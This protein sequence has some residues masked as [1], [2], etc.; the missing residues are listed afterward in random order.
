MSICHGSPAKLRAWAY[1]ILGP[2]TQQSLLLHILQNVL[3]A[4]NMYIKNI[5]IAQIT[6]SYVKSGYDYEIGGLE[7]TR[8]EKGPITRMN[9]QKLKER[10]TS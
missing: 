5:G 3:P 4:Y 1:H 6:F 9:K 8:D 7:V 2:T 10:K